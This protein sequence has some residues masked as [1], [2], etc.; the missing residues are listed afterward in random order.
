MNRINWGRVI[1]G[2]LVAGIVLNLGEWLLNEVV[3]GEDMDALATELGMEPISGSDIGIFVAMT[4]V[5]GILLVWL[6]A[7][8]RP[9]YGPGP[10]TAI[11]AGLVGWIFLGAFW[12]VYNLAWELFPQDMMTTSTIWGFFELPIGTLVGSWLY[13]EGPAATARA[14]L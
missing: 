7:A 3:L 6:Y 10:R 14:A 9:R 12:Y 8:I 4:F 2:G 11:I 13:R 5:L 1:V